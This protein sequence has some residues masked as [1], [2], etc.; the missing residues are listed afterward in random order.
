MSFCIR[1][2]RTSAG[3][4]AKPPRKPE[5]EAIAIRLGRDGWVVEVEIFCLSSS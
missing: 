5:V 3:F 1:T 2:L 4:P